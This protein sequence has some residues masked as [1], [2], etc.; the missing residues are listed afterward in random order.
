MIGSDR[1]LSESTVEHLC[2]GLYFMKQGNQRPT[3]K[4]WLEILRLTDYDLPMAD[5][6]WPS[7]VCINLIDRRIEVSVID[8]EVMKQGHKQQDSNK[9]QVKARLRTAWA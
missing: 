5:L 4:T 2:D 8:L 7:K 3:T 1:A 9:A 6:P